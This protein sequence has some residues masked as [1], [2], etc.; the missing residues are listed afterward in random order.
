MLIESIYKNYFFLKKYYVNIN[1]DLCSRNYIY[2]N[3]NNDN[4]YFIK[5]EKIYTKLKYSRVPQFDTSSGAVASLLAALLGFLITERF[6]FELLDS[7]DFYIIILYFVS[8]L[9]ILRT[10]LFN[11]N[12]NVVCN[13][14][15]FSIGEAFIFFKSLFLILS[16]NI[17]KLKKIDIQLNK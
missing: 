16:R 11:Y 14:S 10:F 13:R 4:I 15:L 17:L 12:N 7:G 5:K 2:L 3:P 8:F 6:G 1:Y 9:I